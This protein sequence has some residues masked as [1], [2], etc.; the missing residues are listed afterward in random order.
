MKP[1]L[2]FAGEQYYPGGG[3]HDYR[4]SFA[5]FT[6]ARDR[7]GEIKGDWYHIVSIIDD[8]YD[9]PQDSWEDANKLD[10]VLY[11]RPR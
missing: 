4:G 2:L 8:A 9:V 5:S 7:A 11:G 3:W 1:Y 6:E 10:D